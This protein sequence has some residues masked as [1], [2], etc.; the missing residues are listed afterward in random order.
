[1]RKLTL[2][3][4]LLLLLPSPTA[5]GGRDY[6]AGDPRSCPGTRALPGKDCADDPHARP[7]TSAAERRLLNGDGEGRPGPVPQD[8]DEDDH[9]SGGCKDEDCERE[10]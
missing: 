3:F 8:I 1:M 6:G 7:G 9:G 5:L 4:G 2:L 10:D